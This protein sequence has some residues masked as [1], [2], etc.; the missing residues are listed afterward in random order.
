METPAVNGGDDLGFS[1]IIYPVETDENYI[2]VDISS[3]N[4]V[5]DLKLG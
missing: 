5:I 1:S 2:Y 4:G 3:C